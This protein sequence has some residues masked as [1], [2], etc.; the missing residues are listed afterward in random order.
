MKKENL[1][2]LLRKLQE[3]SIDQ[4]KGGLRITMDSVAPSVAH[5]L[6]DIAYNFE[7]LVDM[8]ELVIK[9]LKL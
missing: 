5:S 2:Y 3:A 1:D 7:R 6:V 9:R 8:L 4:D